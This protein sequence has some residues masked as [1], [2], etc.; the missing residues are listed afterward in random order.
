MEAKTDDPILGDI[1]VPLLL[2]V[3]MPFV[4]ERYRHNFL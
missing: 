3:S 4:K 1:Y 2:I